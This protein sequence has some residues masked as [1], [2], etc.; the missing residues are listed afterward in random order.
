MFGRIFLVL[1]FL[2]FVLKLSYSN[3]INKNLLFY[4]AYI[5]GS[6][7]FV[8]DKNVNLYIEE[9]TNEYILKSSEYMDIIFHP[10]SLAS[11]D[12]ML[13]LYS[14][15]KKD[16]TLYKTSF[17]SLK[18]LGFNLVIVSLLKF[19]IGRERPYQTDDPFKFDMFRFE[20]TS[21][22]SGH[23]S[24]IFS[25]SY[26]YIRAYNKDIFFITISTMVAISRVVGE[27]HWVSDV[28]YGAII[29]LHIADRLYEK[30]DKN[31]YTIFLNPYL[32]KN[33]I[34][35]KLDIVY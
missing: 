2:S 28:I 23:T 14:K 6:G 5:L 7:S 34:S 13:I 3:E 1:I 29:G 31:N 24:S 10:F 20:D 18:S 35:F 19:S 17:K 15:Y 26:P 22:P 33:M 32:D 30:E 16:S 4:S 11:F 27:Y 21:F 25:W 9:H 8:I 12:I